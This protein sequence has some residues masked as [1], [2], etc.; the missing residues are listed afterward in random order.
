MMGVFLI[1]SLTLID[2]SFKKTSS[3]VPIVLFPH[4]VGPG[5]DFFTQRAGFPTG[6]AS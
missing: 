4:Q 5:L 6:L 1:R 2:L 3:P